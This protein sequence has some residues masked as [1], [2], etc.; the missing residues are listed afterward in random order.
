MKRYWVLINREP[1]IDAFYMDDN[2]WVI[3]YYCGGII[4]YAVEAEKD[5]KMMI[6]F[7][8][9]SKTKSILVYSDLVRRLQN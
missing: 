1:I 9:H 8:D 3:V 4:P 6:D 5:G 2:N 7:L